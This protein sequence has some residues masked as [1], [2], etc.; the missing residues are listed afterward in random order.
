MY[1]WLVSLPK[2]VQ[3]KSTNIDIKGFEFVQDSHL[4]WRDGL[5]VVQDLFSNL[6]FTKY[7]TYDPHIVMCGTEQEYSDFYTGTHVHTIQVSDQI[8]IGLRY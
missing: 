1:A 4:I 7:M 6:I 5:E 2:A 3:W 8:I